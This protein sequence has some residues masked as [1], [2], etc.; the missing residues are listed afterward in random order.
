MRI[1][2]NATSLTERPSGAGQ[3]FI[4]IYGALF[5]SQPQN[6]YL[7]YE[8][9][10]CRVASWFVNQP[11]VIG[12]VTPLRGND[13]WQR[14]LRGATYWN[15]RLRGD[16]LDLFETL[17]LPAVRAPDCPT[18]LTVHDIR[19]GGAGEP[20]VART[21]YH[22]LLRR[23]LRRV[24]AVVTVSDAMRAELAA[25]DPHVS[26]TTIYNGVN[27]VPFEA[28]A[29]KGAAIAQSLGLPNNFLLAVGH[30][31]PRKNYRALV[32][33]M[34][35]LRTTGPD[36]HL[37]IVGRDG[38][39]LEE[40]RAQV[41]ALGLGDR[42]TLRTEVDDAALHRL[43]RSARALVFPSLYEGFGIPLLEAM[44]A[45]LPMAVSDLAVFREL[46]EDQAAYFPPHDPAAIARV[47]GDLLG[48]P[49][50]QQAMI[51]YGFGR[52]G[53]FSFDGL[54]R[55]LDALHQQVRLAKPL[56]ETDPRG[57]A[58]DRS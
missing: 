12:V 17:H 16:R 21:L 14:L 29:R 32:A 44:A 27:R 43:Y 34:T 6:S 23:S 8:P 52:A 9:R 48:S 45:G 33:A 13:R 54:A 38:G 22:S 46:T 3:R 28:A 18:I 56:G 31:E 39:T 26:I 24:N 51:A 37:Q 25:V 15:R 40:T 5:Q 7:I 57:Q 10:D 41:E 49:E 1:G 11:N 30:F 2:I 50:R 47:I 58:G 20:L 19:A 4:G 36:L 35:H 53:D 42:V 55:Q